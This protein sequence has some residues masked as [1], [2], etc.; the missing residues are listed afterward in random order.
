MLKT[1]STAC[2]LLFSLLSFSQ[3][4]SPS[5][6]LKHNQ[7]ATS[8]NQRHGKATNHPTQCGVDTLDYGYEKLI[9][10]L[11]VYS[12]SS[13]LR[14][15]NISTGYRLGQFYTAPGDVTISGFK[16][17][18]WALDT[19]A[20]A[21]D[22]YCEVY[23]IGADSLPTG[24]PVRADT[25]RIDT[26]FRNGVL[27]S[28]AQFANF[29]PYTTDKPF[30]VVVR[31][32][33][34]V[35]VAIVANDY[36]KKDG[37]GENYACGSIGGRWYRSLNLNIGGNALDC[38][39][40][41][42]PFVSYK[43]YNDF[44]LTDCYD[45]KDSVHFK[46]TSSPFYFSPQ[47]N[48][49]KFYEDFR[50]YDYEK[51]SHRWSYGA[52]F[53]YSQI[54]G[55]TKFPNPTNI[56]IG[57]RSILYS[58][59][60]SRACSDTTVKPLNFQP[61]QVDIQGDKDICSGNKATLIGIGSGQIHWYN[62]V[63]DTTALAISPDYETPNA[64][65]ENDTLFAQA[66]NNYCKST[67]KRQ[68]IKVTETPNPPTIKDD[69]ICLNSLA[70]LVA[71]STVGAT[72]WYVDST[73]LVS[74]HTGDF[75]QV[76][77]LTQDTFFFAKTVNGNCT[78]PGR[79]KVKA[80]VS[81]AFA[82]GDPVVSNDTTICLLDGSITLKA[83]AANT[84]RW[85]DV[86]AG[87]NPILTDDSTLVFSPTER[88]THYRYVD[89]YNG[90]CP[91]SRLPI[92]V[93][94]NHF[95]TLPSIVDQE[96]CEGDNI[97]VEYHDLPGDIQW[98]DA[99][100]GGNLVTTSTSVLFSGI[101]QSE[102]F[103]LQPFQGTC[104][105]TVRHQWDYVAI[106]YGKVVTSTLDTQACDLMIPTL[107]VNTDIGQVVWFDKAGAEVYRGVVLALQPLEDDAELSYH[108][109]NNGCVTDRTNHKVYWRTMPDA[110]YDYQVTWRDVN[111]ASRLIGQGDY[112]WE[113]DDATDTSMGT[114]VEH[115]YYQDGDYDVS[116]IVASPFDC[117]D[118]V[119]KKVTIN[120]VGVHDLANNVLTVY[121]NPNNGVFTIRVLN[122][123]APLNIKISDIGGR[124]LTEMTIPIGVQ[125]SHVNLNLNS[126]SMQL[127]D[128]MYLL[129][130]TQGTESF[131]YRLILSN[132]K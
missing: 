67:R 100:T 33:D 81:N 24:T 28:I 86:A 9:T 109:E 32:I 22:V 112:I 91:S 48:I 55:G 8:G 99:E 131:V 121:P 4:T 43:V 65:Y 117:I 103:Y 16:F 122:G 47:Y 105:D 12:S 98:Y 69:S 6:T 20:N 83:S 49:Y 2:L 60:G 84:L 10:N 45:F 18:A 120:S 130:A 25:L 104:Y 107:E 82:P 111:F 13:L 95:P 88:G 11:Y 97:L 62:K 108:I 118:T 74:N 77:P 93:T 14:A 90:I 87:G 73:T 85:F 79:V 1:L 7:N 63:T 5:V 115:H 116:L 42:E 3:F 58:M 128:G 17:Y 78:H 57:L 36:I 70:N 23:E 64:L 61:D 127:S 114:D 34:S 52:G 35:R 19:T 51:Y 123:N 113:F 41:L 15:I 102:T 54:D 68:I 94:V 110:N 72:R 101:L 27:D 66:I 124:L 50:G 119:T 80:Y 39:M 38:D 30:I 59:T 71:T 96:A 75:L 125:S 129:Q 92:E 26:T 29:T 126:N 106:P 53:Y 40:L 76:G 21:V 37:F 31:S 56:N 46:N 132:T 44:T 89:A